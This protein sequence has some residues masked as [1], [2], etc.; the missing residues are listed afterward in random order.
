MQ[1]TSLQFGGVICIL[2]LQFWNKHFKSWYYNFCNNFK[3][4]I[5]MDSLILYIKRKIIAKVSM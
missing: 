5:I 2:P 4:D 3:N 1:N